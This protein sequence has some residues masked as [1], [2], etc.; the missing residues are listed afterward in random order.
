MAQPDSISNT[1][2]TAVTALPD[3]LLG[4]AIDTVDTCVAVL[5]GRNL[6]FSFVNRAFQAL[7]PHTPMVGRAFAD[8]FDGPD[9]AE[10][11]AALL[12]V[13]ETGVRWKAERFET[14]SEEDGLRIWDGEVV[15]AAGSG[16]VAGSGGADSIV[17][18]A[19]NVTAA[20]R[21]ERA[22]AASEEALR[23]SNQKLRETID[24]ITDGVVVLDRDWR[25]TV[26][27]DRAAAIVGMKP[28]DLIGG[29][30]WDIFPQ[31]QDTKYYQCY[32]EAMRTGVPVHFEEYYPPLDL[33]LECNCY[34]SLDGLTV[35]FRD[36]SE[37]HQ[38]EQALRESTALLSAISDNSPD[39]IY[40]KDAQGRLRFANPATLALIGKPLDQILGRTDAELLAD[41]DVARDVMANDRR[42][43]DSGAGE[44]LEELVPMPGGEHR[45]WLSMKT[46]LCDRDGAV[47]G[48]LGISRDITDRKR[49]EQRLRDENHRKDE[50]LA[51][52]A[53]ELR[54]PLAPIVTG[55]RLL[56]ISAHDEG[57]V[58]QAA[59]I[60][61][62][63][64]AH[65]TELVDDLLD[66]SRVTRGLIELE[67][68][69]IDMRLVLSHAVEQVR[70]LIEA[71]QHRFD[72]ALGAEPACVHGDQTRLIQTVS[73]LL[74][75]AA[76]YTP[77]GGHISLSL[78]AN[79]SEVEVSVIDTGNGIAASLLPKVFDL[80]SQGERTPDRS[81]G[82]LGLGLSLVKSIVAMHGGRVAA[83]S[84]GLGQGSRFS[85]TLPRLTRTGALADTPAALES[86]GGR[87]RRVMVVDDN[88]DAGN[89]LADLLE[90]HGH[91]VVVKT[92][93][94]AA[95]AAAGV[96][97]PDVF[98]LDIGLPDMNGYELASR[99]RAHPA[100]AGATLV[101]LTGYGQSKDRDA[102]R[103]A[104]FDHYFVKPVNAEAL[105]QVLAL[106]LAH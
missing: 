2:V 22:L 54:N 103:A 55:A 63:Q 35:Y 105:A 92:D 17:I 56:D 16:G 24:S 59:R 77:A 97:A 46:A 41:P 36:V 13:F 82:G 68:T 70:P 76:K 37:R 100:S 28:E 66:V 71:R 101:A 15:P 79:D 25:Y 39:V 87:A 12:R 91:R 10:L 40:A 85:I 38:A 88:V 9:S 80:F 26:V 93:A 19:R 18:L 31:A 48:L 89:T 96:D 106:A 4:V 44:E 83:H 102:G 74:N 27:S 50:F 67:K 14:M 73:N 52:L 43:M 64:A 72:V 5:A 69:D 86:R 94:K 62:R 42:I 60:I 8:V 78:V 99:L 7:R 58:R 21:V 3:A 1:V 75:N 57:K 104:G 61:S 6:R 29:C 65:M 32:H 49:A 34:S 90:A 23:R 47:V 30:I 95:L 51:M 20:V 11:R 53:H 45:I 84:D 33:W 98:I 81:Q